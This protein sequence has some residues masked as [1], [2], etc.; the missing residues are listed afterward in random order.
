MFEVKLEH[1]GPVL[2]RG[3]HTIGIAPEQESGELP[4]AGLGLHDSAFGRALLR[5]FQ[6]L[7]AIADLHVEVEFIE[8]RLDDDRPLRLAG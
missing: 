7:S 1:V 2:H 5:Q 8:M 3:A 6:R 4:I